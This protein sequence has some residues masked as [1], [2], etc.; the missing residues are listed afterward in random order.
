MFVFRF[1]NRQGFT[2][3]SSYPLPQ[4]I[5]LPFYTIG[6][7]GIFAYSLVR[8]FFEHVAVYLIIVGIHE[9]LHGFIRNEGPERCYSE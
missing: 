3:K 9:G 4:C 5:I 7:F 2:Y 6:L 1:R 8:V